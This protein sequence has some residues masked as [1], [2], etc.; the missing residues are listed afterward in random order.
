MANDENKTAKGLLIGFLA[1]TVV[2]AVI[3]LLYAPKPG[4]ELRADIKQ[5]ASDLKEDA[6]EYLKIAKQKAVSIIKE[7]KRQSEVLLTDA[8]K[9]A[10]TIIQ[11]ADK[12][13]SDVKERT[14]EEGRKI[15]DA[16][17]AGVDAYKKDRENS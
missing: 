6:E 5:K 10:E 14:T 1:G 9:K 15:K 13:F 3:A 17:Q 11:D 16:F 2:G 8:K 4:K 12:I 7:G